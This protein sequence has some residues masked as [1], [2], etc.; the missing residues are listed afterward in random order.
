MS[1]HI[2]QARGGHLRRGNLWPRGW[3]GWAVEVKEV[4]GAASFAAAVRL[5]LRSG[6]RLSDDPAFQRVLPFRGLPLEPL[7]V[8]P[9]VVVG[10]VP[11]RSRRNFSVGVKAAVPIAVGAAFLSG[12]I[13]GTSVR[14]ET[15]ADVGSADGGFRWRPATIV[16]FDGPVP[17][18]HD[19]AEGADAE[20]QEDGDDNG[21]GDSGTLGVVH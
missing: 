11:G 18:V 5:G 20:W 2:L 3:K 4:A 13:S 19:E 9:D 14:P 7:V 6:H 12:R 16:S 17:E 21:G 1:N 8:V 15:L 10:I